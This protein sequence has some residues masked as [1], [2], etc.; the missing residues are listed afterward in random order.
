M[1]QRWRYWRK[2]VSYQTMA[3][4]SWKVNWYKARKYLICS[5]RKKLQ[6]FVCHLWNFNLFCN[7]YFAKIFN[8]KWLILKVGF[9]IDILVLLT[10][11][12]KDECWRTLI[13]N[14]SPSQLNAITI[15]SR[16]DITKRSPPFLFVA[17]IWIKRSRR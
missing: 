12:V 6:N 9:P 15:F 3:N 10:C 16:A 11:F 17:K 2:I 13:L 1:T 5:C 4:H 8:T 14:W 7:W